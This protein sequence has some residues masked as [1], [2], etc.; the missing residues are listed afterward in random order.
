MSRT[1]RRSA[2]AESIA[3]W[4]A[5]SVILLMWWA[6]AKAVTWMRPHVEMP[7]GPAALSRNVPTTKAIDE[8]APK[9]TTIRASTRPDEPTLTADVSVTG[10]DVANLRARGLMIPARGVSL[11]CLR[12]AA[13]AASPHGRGTDMRRS[14]FS[15]RAAQTW[16]P[17]RTGKWRNCLRATQ[18]G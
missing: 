10:E 14:T 11:N 2:H 4:L 5:L 6:G 12:I 17:W 3:P 15:R 7:A 13:T 8:A 9:E 16:L 18:A 1:Y